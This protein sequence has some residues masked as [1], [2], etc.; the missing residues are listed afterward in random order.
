[1]RV[2]GSYHWISSAIGQDRLLPQP[3]QL[4]PIELIFRR[5]LSQ[6]RGTRHSSLIE[7]AITA[8][9]MKREGGIGLFCGVSIRLA[10]EEKPRSGKKR[11]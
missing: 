6:T 9:T 8:T 10:T 1:M 5:S 3:L 4:T 2:C 7:P 11:G